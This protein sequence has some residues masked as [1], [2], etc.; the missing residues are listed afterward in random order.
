MFLATRHSPL[1]G[2]PADIVNKA[3]GEVAK[4]LKDVALRKRFAEQALI[5]VGSAPAETAK[6]LRAEI[7]K[8]AEVITTAG[9][10]PDS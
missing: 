1:A 9:V 6:F 7:D 10:K 2:T 3:Q 5:P 4:A 8:W